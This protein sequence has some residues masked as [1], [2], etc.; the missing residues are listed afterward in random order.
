MYFTCLRSDVQHLADRTVDEGK[1]LHK[2]C[3]WYMHRDKKNYIV[4]STNLMNKVFQSMI[5]SSFDMN[6]K[7]TLTEKVA[8]S[9]WK[10]DLHVLVILL[11]C[12][13]FLH[14][15]CCWKWIWLETKLLHAVK[16][17]SVQND[18]ARRRSLLLF[19][20][21]SIIALDNSHH[22]ARIVHLCK[23]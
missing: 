10:A 22:L 3:G 4:P 16:R 8:T 14:S 18:W 5:V 12:Y 15:G 11:D 1:H 7:H 17:F 9:I 19:I 21:S 13:G 23:V 20:S 2:R 6:T